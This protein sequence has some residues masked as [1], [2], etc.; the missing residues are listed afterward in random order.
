[1]NL[2]GRR[3]QLI[4]TIVMCVVVMALGI[5]VVAQQLS[6][7]RLSGDIAE[8]KRLIAAQEVLS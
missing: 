6:A 2:S 7:T 5:G 8:Q 1:M 4:A 3:P